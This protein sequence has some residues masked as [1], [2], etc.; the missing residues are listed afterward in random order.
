MM[1]TSKLTTSIIFLLSILLSSKFA[2]GKEY[3]SLAIYMAENPKGKHQGTDGN[4]LK[5]DR[6][7]SNE[8][9]NQAN[10]INI[11]NKMATWSIKILMSVVHFTYGFN[12]KL[13]PWALKPGGQA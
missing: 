8:I 10:F 4:W 12:I 11:K 7:K 1:N 3:Q 9:W 2:L 13:I 6:E 5:S